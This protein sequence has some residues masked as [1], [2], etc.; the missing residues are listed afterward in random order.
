MTL[1]FLLTII[2]FAVILEFVIDAGKEAGV[3][4]IMIGMGVG[5]VAFGLAAYALKK[6]VEYSLKLE[7][8]LKSQPQVVKT[9][10]GLGTAVWLFVLLLGAAFTASFSTEFIV[11]QMAG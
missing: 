10:I 7:D 8:R 5:L 6:T 3:V 4:G 11:E 9:L 2:F 1:Q